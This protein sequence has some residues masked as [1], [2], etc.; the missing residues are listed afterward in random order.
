MILKAATYFITPHIQWVS[1]PCRSYLPGAIQIHPFLCA[2][3]ITS[4]NLPWTAYH[5]THFLSGLLQSFLHTTL[6]WYFKVLN[7]KSFVCIKPYN[8]FSL[9]LG[10]NPNSLTWTMSQTWSESCFVIQ[11]HPL[12]FFLYHSKTD[13]PS[14]PLKGQGFSCLST[15]PLALYLA[16]VLLSTLTNFNLPLRILFNQ[17]FFKIPC[18]ALIFFNVNSP[19]DSLSWYSLFSFV[20][21]TM[22]RIYAFIWILKCLITNFLTGL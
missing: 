2:S 18:E 19:S 6:R 21:L 12:C 7:W 15:S 5:V 10:Q 16:R 1:N 11:L 9:H 17:H 3:A 8:N 13:L 4:S 22:I 14:V 20:R